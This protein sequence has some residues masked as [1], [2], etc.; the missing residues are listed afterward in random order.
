M[1]VVA[2]QSTAVA[3]HLAVPAV[4]SDVSIN[5]GRKRFATGKVA[6]AAGDDDTSVFFLLPVHSS[7]VVT[8]IKLYHDAITGGTDFNVGLYKAD[9][10]DKDENC[11]ADA[12]SLATAS[13]AGTE[14]AFEARDVALM[15][16]R[17]W[18]DAGD[19]ADPGLWYMLALT[20]VTVGT[21][22]GDV[23]VDLTYTID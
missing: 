18:Q 13:T 1:G 15:G 4:V 5:G 11:Y 2:T 19:T 17:V 22:A 23:V 16:Q 21:A 14:V 20:G 9:L 8:S 7:W 6:I 10:T 3:N 12:I